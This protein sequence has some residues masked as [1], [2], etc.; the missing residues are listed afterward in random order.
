MVE[1]VATLQHLEATKKAGTRLL[2]VDDSIYGDLQHH[3]QD[4]SP[5]RL[6]FFKP[7]ARLGLTGE[8]FDR[9]ER[10]A[11][12]GTPLRVDVNREQW[13]KEYLERDAS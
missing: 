12:T 7:D 9:I 5:K 2:W 10:W 4:V 8:D 1:H 13:L 6:S 11:S 3:L